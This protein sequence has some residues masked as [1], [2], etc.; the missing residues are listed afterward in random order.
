M[1][2]MDTKLKAGESYGKQ[3]E[4]LRKEN[5]PQ[6]LVVDDSPEI[7]DLLTDILT[8]HS[9]RVRPAFSGRM[10]LK[11]VEAEVPDLIM[12]DVTMPEMDGYEV[13]RHLK[14]NEKSCSIPVIFISGID[15]AANKVEGFNAGGIDYITKPFRSAE[16]LARVEKHLAVRRLQKQLEG[17]NIQLQQ[18]ITERR[19]A[20]EELRK[21]KA[22]LEEIVAERTKDIRNINEEL[23]C[24]ITERKQAEELYRTL[25]N[26]SHTGVY[27]VQNGKLQF[28][29]P[30]IPE[31]SGYLEEELIEMDILDFVYPDDREIVR[32]NAVDML[33]GKRSTP[34][35]FRIV[36]R[37]GRIRWLM[38]MVASITY[39]GKQAVLGN[40]MDITEKIQAESAL[41]ESE[42]RISDISNNMAD[43]IW[44]IDKNGVYSYSS[45][46]VLTVLGYTP[47]EIIGK[48]FSD[49][50]LAENLEQMRE[51]LIEIMKDKKPIKDLESWRTRKNGEHVCLIT[52]G[53]PF[54]DNQ[55]HFKGYRGV[56]RDITERK[57]AEEAIEQANY[58]LHSMVYEYSLRYQ[59]TSLFNQMSEK[60]QICGSLEETYSIMSQFA[61]KLFPAAAGSLFIF[62]SSRN[63]VEA[64]TFWGKGLSGEKVFIPEDCCALRHGKRHVKADSLSDSRC[65]HL[66]GTVGKSSLCV[67]LSAQGKTIGM[68]HLQQQISSGSLP[69]KPDFYERS[70][71][72]NVEMQQL[73]ITMADL[74]SLALA[75][76]KLRDTLKQQATRDPLTGL[77]NRRYMEETLTREIG[78]SERYGT[79]VGIIMIDI[80]HFRRFNNTFGHEA[81]DIVLKDLGKFLQ[82]NV[83]K[84]DV[85]CRYGGE[86]FTLIMPGASLEFTQKRAEDIRRTV[87][88]LRIYYNEQPLE[89][90]TLSLGVAIFPDHGSTGEAVLQVADAALYTAKHRGRNQVAVA[91]DAKHDCRYPEPVAE[92][93]KPAHI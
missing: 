79:P 63:L 72:I 20:E 51:I 4:E 8:N 73:A 2:Q 78:R 16:V 42:K 6:I 91:G 17:Q 7:M 88:H 46:K 40:T 82:I 55:G 5:P 24:E 75:N 77:F 52:N 64:V 43:W 60:L 86:E 27:I 48:S 21:H 90:I 62:D 18:E 89:S 14:S 28:V 53:V 39:E 92:N 44:E 41:R 34:Y 69:A 45:E 15:E 10:A 3:A 58:K 35:E 11:S 31:Y 32:K 38:E 85:A 80:D 29:N 36:D 61:Q 47:E 56:N 50:F 66:S 65:P 59:R 54:F 13:C 83:R 57:R 19:Q 49:F 33:E 1:N 93:E 68:L 23:Q 22:Q 67:P 84:E 9:Y 30:H 76:I 25:A 12:L 26:N 81:G 70:E 71:G 37:E 87:Q 74:F